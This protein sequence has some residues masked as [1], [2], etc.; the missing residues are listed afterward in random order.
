MTKK[1]LTLQDLFQE[2]EKYEVKE[3]VKEELFIPRIDASITIQKPERSLCIE[4]VQ[5]GRN[6]EDGDVFLVYNAVVAPD[7]KDKD[8]QKAF[9][10]KEPTDIVSKIFEAGEIVSIAQVALDLAGYGDSVSRM[11]DLKN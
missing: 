5:M 4:S 7:L 9:G 1:K 6:D 2:K 10:C 11:K 3:D 8:L